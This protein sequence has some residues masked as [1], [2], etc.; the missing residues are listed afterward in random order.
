[1]TL[2][3]TTETNRYCL[4]ESA[5][6]YWQGG[7]C[8]YYFA[9]DLQ[10]L[11]G[12]L[13]QRVDEGM[14]KDANRRLTPSHAKS[15]QEYLREREDWLLGAMLLGISSQAVEFY[16][17]K[18]EN[19]KPD[20]NFGELR[21]LANQRN[22]MRIFDGQHRRR[23]IGDLIQEL[24]DSDDISSEH[25]ASIL[26]ASVPV[27][28]YEE[29]DLRSLRQM[30]SDASKT[31]KI[32][33]NV[34]T[35]FDGR[36]AFNRAAMHL[37]EE[38]RLFGGRVEMEQTSVSAGSSS[39]LSINQLSANLKALE[40]GSRGRLSRARNDECMGDLDAVYLR[41]MEWSDKFLPAARTEYESL[42]SGESDG[43]D[44]PAMRRR[45]LAFSVTFI[46]ILA[47]SYYQWHRDVGEDWKPLAQYVRTANLTPGGGYGSLLV[48]AG[49]MA[50]GASSPVA[51]RQ[52]VQGAINYIVAE[53]Q[54]AAR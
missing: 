30:F 44:I 52:E 23:A 33:A 41:C 22:T 48:D 8:V 40:V 27:S 43:S 36:Y 14:V 21:I 18:D 20:I 24:T 37:S 4:R 29:E 10:E 2:Q 46:R 42:V 12:L 25:R 5:H 47:G 45:S 50:P 16:P 7:R 1:M 6:R 53:A 28:L 49:A 31:K 51:R 54:K 3:I 17:Y 9:L 19:G 15:I 35:I 34:V 38:S 32:E 39:L 11:D 26:Q 13:P